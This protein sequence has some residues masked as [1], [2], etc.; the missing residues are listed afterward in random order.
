MAYGPRAGEC[1]AGVEVGSAQ[2]PGDGPLTYAIVSGAKK[3]GL[4]VT[5]SQTSVLPKNNLASYFV[6]AE[7]CLRLLPQRLRENFPVSTARLLP[8]SAG[9]PPPGL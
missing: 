7:E 5:A 3:N 2:G 1:S 8:G 4:Q 6:T 9:H